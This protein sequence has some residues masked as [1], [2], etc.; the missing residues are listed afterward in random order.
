MTDESNARSTV[1]YS[2]LR[3]PFLTTLA[4]TAFLMIGGAVLA[5]GFDPEDMAFPVGGDDYRITDSFG[6][7]RDGCSRL[8]EGVDIMAPEGAPVYAVADGVAEWVSPNQDLCCRLQIDHGD[9]WITRYIHLL[10]DRTDSNGNFIWNDD[11]FWGIAPGIEDGTPISKGQLIGWVGDSGNAPEGVTHLHFELRRKTGDS[12]KSTPLDSYQY[13]LLAE[14][15]YNGQ[16]YDDDGNTHENDIEKIFAADITRGCNP[17]T[18]NRYCPDAPVSRGAMAAFINRT[19]GLPAAT[20]DYFSDDN[21]NI[22]EGDINAITEAGIGFGCG[23]DSYCPDDD[24]LREEFAEMF[25]RAFGY[26]NPGGDDFFT[27]DNDSAYEESINALKVADVTKGC[28]PP[29]NDRFCPYLPVDRA[30]M[31]SFFV[32]ALDL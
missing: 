22:F 21:G 31:A 15:S 20:Q 2:I 32:R 13:L 3:R 16:F 11:Q 24:L 7:C 6:D 27:D 29:D 17:P 25:T 19:L 5:S 23:N 10:D 26:T 4:I 14:M 8:H 30:A 28:N 18:N 9:G 1:G 12:W